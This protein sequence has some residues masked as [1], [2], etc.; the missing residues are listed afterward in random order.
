MQ[1]L[2]LAS[3]RGRRRVGRARA[4]PHLGATAGHERSSPGLCVQ[5]SARPIGPGTSSIADNAAAPQV[6]MRLVELFH[7]QVPACAALR[8]NLARH[9]CTISSLLNSSCGGWTD[10]YC[11]LLQSAPTEHSATSA[12][13]G[14]SD[15]SS[16]A[17]TCRLGVSMA[18]LLHHAVVVITISSSACAGHCCERAMP[19]ATNWHCDRGFMGAKADAGAPPRPIMR[20]EGLNEEM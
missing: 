19:R 14:L 1:A 17:S 20:A 8:S 15:C 11:G 18:D 7:P 13:F 12:A 6:G 5:R 9:L 4:E 2:G 3:R 10:Q 16:P